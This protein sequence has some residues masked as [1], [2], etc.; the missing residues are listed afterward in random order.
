[1]SRI[2]QYKESLISYVENSDIK[3]FINNKDS[4]IFSTLCLTVMNNVQKK[5]NNKNISHCYDIAS[6][7][8]IIN[9]CIVNPSMFGLKSMQAFINQLSLNLEQ[10]SPQT[11]N[12]KHYLSLFKFINDK[13][14]IIYTG[15]NNINTGNNIKTNIEPEIIHETI[16][17]FTNNSV[18]KTN[19][20]NIPV[21]P[22]SINQIPKILFI[23]Y[24]N[25]TYGELTNLSLL[26]AWILGGN[27]Y[28]MAKNLHLL[29][30]YFGIMYKIIIDINN[31]DEDIKKMDNQQYSL[32][33]I[34]NY[35]FQDTFELYIENKQK[36]LEGLITLELM[37]ATI[38]E[39]IKYMD[40]IIDSIISCT[41]PLIPV[42]PSQNI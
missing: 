29:G 30:S 24:I 23:K 16:N 34:I 26:I 18:I 14:N 42:S 5:L 41:S 25:N 40:D 17:G 39:I 35:G 27:N 13:Y 15:V 19:K 32:N 1:M 6:S 3:V 28:D 20:L 37:S 4:Y 7:L 36:L 10:L 11:K 33:Y 2:R 8:E 22:C 9:K 31:F 21:S 38:K 12:I